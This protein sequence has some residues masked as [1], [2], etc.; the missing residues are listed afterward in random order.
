MACFFI[1]ASYGDNSVFK[2]FR[3][4]AE[5][6]ARRN[7]RVVVI[8]AGQRY[9][10]VDLDS[11]PSTLTWPSVRP[12]KWRDGTFLYSL[13]RE[14]RPDCVIGNFA[15]VN[16]CLLLSKVCAVPNRIA[17]YHSMSSAVD[18]DNVAPKW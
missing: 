17:W 3:A 13:I 2:Y 16:L 10:A 7:N 8:V 6:L 4:L 14:R 12:T 15:A 9:D 11:N 1:T 18:I 5:E